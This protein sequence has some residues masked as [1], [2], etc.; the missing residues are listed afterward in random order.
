MSFT[1]SFAVLAYAAALFSCV[2]SHAAK[3]DWA[4]GSPG[5]SN[6]ATRDYY[7]RGGFLAWKNFMG[8]WRD[9]NGALQ[10][11]D[12]YAMAEI[13]DND[14]GRFVEWDVSELVRL[15]QSGKHQNQGLFLR[16]IKQ[17]G[18]IL[19][20]SREHPQ[21]DHRPQL[22]VVGTEGSVSLTP[23]A[24]TYLTKS[25]Y[26]SQGQSAD[27]RVSSAPDHALLRFDL[28]KLKDLGRIS[29]ASL[30]LFTTRQY[31]DATIGVFRCSQG[32]DEPTSDPTTGLASKYRSDREIGQDEDVIFATDFESSK[33]NEEWTYA[34]K[35]EV[36]DT[37]SADSKRKFQPFDGKALRVR[38]A[39]GSTGALNTLFKFKSETG[40]EP[41]EIYFRYY[42]RLADDWNQTI[43][44]GK[45]PGISGTYGIAGWGGRKS[46][47]N[48]G[49]SARGLFKMTIP[50]GNPLAGTTP[51]GTY[52][53]HADMEG[54][55]GTNWVWQK[56]Y[57]GF[58]EN[59]RWY[60]LEQYLKLNTPS[61]KDGILR[62]WVDGRLAF[63]KTDIRFRHAEKLK[64]E[65]VW[66]NVYHGGTTPSPYNQHV[67]IDN[68]VIAK[69]YI[70]PM[71]PRE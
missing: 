8:D 38:I 55:Y 50:A 67:F 31:G 51:I 33:W 71:A 42:L 56:D 19:F 3:N 10:G 43:Q 30:R 35:L 61:K 4:E 44:G 20:C 53:Y 46:N 9:A 68:V 66:M 12:T 11:N 37:V 18:N 21:A 60:S 24:D 48:N 59:N 52:C 26:R 14:T 64:I 1:N 47:G 32:H 15:W 36:I 34:G 29:S 70:G 57:R 63:E 27:L 45:L 17:G 6:G 5:M 62:A 39:E 54:N 25:T 41:E 2:A 23:E 22:V 16:T 69:K 28:G 49:W 58:L 65:Q 40:E 7:N 13:E